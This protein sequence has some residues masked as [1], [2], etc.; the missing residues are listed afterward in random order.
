MALPSLVGGPLPKTAPATGAGASTALWVKSTGWMLSPPSSASDIPV[1]KTNIADA[2]TATARVSN[3]LLLDIFPPRLDL[4]ADACQTPR[5]RAI[6][7]CAVL[8]RRHGTV[9]GAI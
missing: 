9:D 3:L 5:A 8:A 4:P 7:G 6:W 2:A 1:P